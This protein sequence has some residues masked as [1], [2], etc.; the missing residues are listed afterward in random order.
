MA[1]LSTVRWR[2]AYLS[3]LG[4]GYSVFPHARKG[5]ELFSSRKRMLR[6]VYYKRVTWK[7]SEENENC[8]HISLKWLGDEFNKARLCAETTSRIYSYE[9]LNNWVVES[10]SFEV[11]NLE[12]RIRRVG[13]IESV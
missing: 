9:V 11:Q 8:E 10:Y 5:F 2:G 6:M 7:K 4:G 13:L 1:E 12:V 3:G